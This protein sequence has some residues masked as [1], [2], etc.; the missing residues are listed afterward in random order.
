MPLLSLL[1]TKSILVIIGTKHTLCV[2][3]RGCLGG[4]TLGCLGY[5]PRLRVASPL[6]CL[7]S[8]RFVFHRRYAICC[9]SLFASVLLFRACDCFRFDVCTRRICICEAVYLLST[10]GAAPIIAATKVAGTMSPPSLH[11]TRLNTRD[12]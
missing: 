8:S 7:S 10:S 12:C 1:Q 2:V 9:F 3:A 11:Q 5:T 6:L 4:I